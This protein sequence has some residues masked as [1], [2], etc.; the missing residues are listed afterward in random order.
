MYDSVRQ[1]DLGTIEKLD[2][3][4]IQKDIEQGLNSDLGE[5]VEESIAPD[6]V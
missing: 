5:S 6:I 1:F 2:L 4:E 3:E